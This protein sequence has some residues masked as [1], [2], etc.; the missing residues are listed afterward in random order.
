MNK[1]EQIINQCDM[2]KEKH[3]NYFTFT[4]RHKIC[5]KCFYKIIIRSYLKDIIKSPDLKINCICNRG[6]IKLSIQDLI[7]K[8][9]HLNDKKEDFISMKKKQEKKEECK[10][11][12]KQL[13]EFCFDCSEEICEE[14]KDDKEKHL[15]HNILNINLFQEDFKEK[16]ESL[17]DLEDLL[18]WYDK[19]IKNLFPQYIK[20]LDEKFDILIK[21]VNDYRKQIKQMLM[22][23]IQKFTNPMKLSYLLYKFFNYEKNHSYN[24]IHQII[25]I[26]NTK[27][28]FPELNLNFDKFEN[29]I[30]SIIKSVNTLDLENS[31]ELKLKEKFLNF[32][33]YQNIEN[34]HNS[35]IS[36]ISI[37][38]NNK[39]ISGD[40]DGNL[41][42]WKQT[43]KGFNNIQKGKAH[44]G[45]INN[46][47]YINYGKFASTSIKDNF[48]LI[49]KENNND[50]RYKIIEKYLFDTGN[51]CIILNILNDKNTLISSFNDNKIHILEDKD[52][53]NKYKEIKI[54]GEHSK[55]INS[56]IQLQTGEIISGSD[57]KT[58]KIWKKYILSETLIG[59]KD[60]V[61]DIIELTNNKICS[62]SSDKK[63]IIWERK[64]LIDKF[65]LYQILE[66][67]LD[68]IRTLIGLNDGRI[69][70]GSIDETI[71]IWVKNKEKYECVDTLLI[72][73]AGVSKLVKINDENFVSC[74]WDKSI[75][76]WSSFLNN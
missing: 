42:L 9:T 28:I 41:K 57:D 32:K 37:L 1:E 76:I 45:K 61:T 52:K 67:H 15:N 69:I 73:K 7:D 12:S 44:N 24:N 30:E 62:S 2:C 13:T 54:F 18:N 27:I 60:Y 75:K 47:V 17:P 23:K 14:C 53:N 5:Y 70:S 66:S 20:N 58:L 65:N 46:L 21:S 16:I 3:E 31:I 48:I 22:L 35:D 64:N 56:I 59:H 72:N 6:N 40:Y 50:E 33:I 51:F 8:F 71:K 55:S 63:I 25:F 19:E 43:F 74:S 26:L 39:L 29:K 10:I 38:S 4:C 49:W 68:S 11:H 34:A 36:C